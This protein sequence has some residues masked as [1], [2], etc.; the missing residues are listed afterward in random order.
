MCSQLCSQARNETF[1]EFT[2]LQLDPDTK[3]ENRPEMYLRWQV[4]Y[5]KVSIWCNFK[6]LNHWE[7]PPR[8]SREH[9]NLRPYA[10]LTRN[11]HFCF[12]CSRRRCQNI[13]FLF[14]RNKPRLC[15]QQLLLTI[16]ADSKSRKVAADICLRE[17]I[18]RCLCQ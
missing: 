2:F 6:D 7:L 15:Y 9:N 10:I 5:I 16:C 11:F 1:T 13:S 12:N 17:N 18:V 3:T 8:V 4:P 14:H